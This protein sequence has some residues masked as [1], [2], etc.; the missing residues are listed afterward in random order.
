MIIEI[1]EPSDFEQTG[2]DY[3]NLAADRVFSILSMLRESGFDDAWDEAEIRDFWRA[4]QRELASALALVQQGTEFLMKARIAGV[5]PFLLIAEGARGLPRGADTR[6]VAFAEFRTV[7][8][9]DLVRL[10]N[11]VSARR[12]VPSFAQQFD[13]LRKRRNTIMHTVDQS[14]GFTAKEILLLILEDV[15]ELAGPMRWMSIR[16][17]YADRTPAAAIGADEYLESELIGEAEQ[18]MLLLTRGELRKYFGFVNNQRAYLCPV[19]RSRERYRD[20]LQFTAQLHPNTPS[21]TNLYCFVC[22]R[23][24]LV[25]RLSCSEDDCRGNV[26]LVNKREQQCLTCL[27]TTQPIDAPPLNLSI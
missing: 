24:T 25:R 19:C 12:L 10:Y 6:D 13:R 22:D 2:L 3:L 20:D 9:Q 17:E 11:A 5:S 21:S 26:I 15:H 4:S 23:S 18:L 27:A 8:A 14:L 7:D 16:R 1:P